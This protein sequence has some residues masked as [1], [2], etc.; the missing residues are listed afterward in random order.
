M[1]KESDIDKLWQVIKFADFQ[2]RNF[3][4]SIILSLCVA[5]LEF[6]NL[7][8]FLYTTRALIN[9]N[10][11]FLRDSF[12]F[13][14]L[15]KAYLNNLDTFDIRLFTFLVVAVGIAKFSSLVLSY[16]S[17]YYYVKWSSFLI[18]RLRSRLFTRCL[19]FGKLFFDR[20][21]AGGLHTAIIVHVGE[22]KFILGIFKEF[23]FWSFLG[24][25]YVLLMFI[26][27][28]KLAFFAMLIAPIYY[29]SQIKLAKKIRATSW[30]VSKFKLELGRRFHNVILCI[31]FIKNY[32]S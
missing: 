8:L 3:I 17:G 15:P 10:F 6:L 2:P 13:D 24:A 27:A 5:L 30:D 19:S 11:L 28:W 18:D 14:Y 26:L 25:V 23:V 21:S 9:K 1:K 16:F 12:A 4:F 32:L 31:P 22:L 20:R 29:F 7:G